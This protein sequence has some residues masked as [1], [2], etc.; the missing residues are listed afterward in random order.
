MGPF[1]REGNNEFG[2]WLPTTST[3]GSLPKVISPTHG[4]EGYE[5]RDF[6]KLDTLVTRFSWAFFLS[7][8]FRNTQAYVLRCLNVSGF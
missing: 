5:K 8:K 6:M 3:N 7:G 4:P 2:E 1:G